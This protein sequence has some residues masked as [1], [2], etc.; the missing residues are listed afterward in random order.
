MTLSPALLPLLRELGDLKRIRSAGRDGTVATRLFEM[1]WSAW[2][3][4]EDRD[5]VAM[6]AMAQALAACRL[7]DLDHAKLG[8]LGMSGDDRRTALERAVD[9]IAAPL[10]DDHAAALKTYLDAPL[11]PPG[12][13]PDAIAALRHQPRA[14]VTGPGRPRIML[15]PEENHAEHSFLVALYA[16]LLAPFYGAP[17]ARSFWHGMVHHLHSAAM[18]DAGY[19]G[20]V[21]LG[22]RLGSVID[23]A[24]ELAL[25]QLP[26][27]PAAV[28][29]EHLLEIADDTTPAA[30]AFHAGDVIDRVVEIEQHLKRGA[31]TMDVVL[32]DYGLV[33]D[34]PVK[35]FHDRVL[36][37]T[38][39]P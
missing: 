33:H 29:R 24:R 5:T 21:L 32:G 11:S 15:Q 6:R 30:R 10:P 9:E 31:V 4:G 1:A 36:A 38:G 19:T 27:K 25:A 39:L 13:L 8:E 20:E 2:L 22:D 35:P 34:G 37:E 17:P 26:D 16:S 28:S 18:P 14:G 12:P 7:G 23:R 3:A